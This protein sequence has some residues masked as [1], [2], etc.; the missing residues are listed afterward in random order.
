MKGFRLAAL[1]LAVASCALTQSVCYSQKA[2]EIR[3]TTVTYQ[4]GVFNCG[5][6]GGNYIN[7]YGIPFYQKGVQAGSTWLYTSTGSGGPYG[8]GFFFN[9]P[10]GGTTDLSGQEFTITSSAFNPPGSAVTPYPTYPSPPYNCNGDCN[11][12][13]ATITG[14]T[15]DDGG[16]YTASATI[17]FFYYISCAHGCREYGIVTGGTIT[18]KYQ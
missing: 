15:P 6:S 7:C 17:H 11:T 4:V 8:W 16:T 14:T 3:G 12:F 18:V 13:T 10:G 2:D 1:S 9:P 5:T